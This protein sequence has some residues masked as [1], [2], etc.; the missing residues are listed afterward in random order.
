VGISL[1]LTD[2]TTTISLSGTSPVLGATY[3]VGTSQYRNGEWQPVTEDAEVNLR[4]TAAAIRST[5]AS[6]EML[7]QAAIR[8][9]ETGVGDRVY[10]TFAPLSETAYRSEI[11]DGRVV[12]S[13]DPGLRRL[14]DT[15]PTV[16]I[17]V[18]WTRAPGWDGD[19]T[20]IS[21]SANGQAAS[22]SAR[23][24]T[25]D[26]ANG[27]WVQMAAAQVTG[28]MPTPVMLELTNTSGGSRAYR[29][30]FV[31][32]NA[33]S[34][35]ANLVHY[36]QGEAVVS[37]G[38]ASADG[39]SSGGNLLTITASTTAT[40]Y[41]WT[42]P[43]ADMQRTKG[44]RARILARV[45]SVAD[46][47]YVRPKILDGGGAQVLWSGD[48]MVVPYTSSNDT[49]QDFGIVPLP[50]G[51][52][53]A[54]YAAHRL[55]LEIR[56]SAGGPGIELDVM[57]LTMLDAYRYAELNSISVANNAALVLD[58]VE[59]R[60]YISASSVWTPLATSFGGPLLLQPNTLQRIH[61]LY[62][63]AATAGVPITSTL[64]VRA[65]FR[66]RRLTV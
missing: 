47:I 30:L 37:G 9:Q 7:L 51:G 49:L 29:K 55:G 6:I 52:Y 12:W 23:T 24:L 19:L 5:V 41:Q 27:N 56:V 31:N 18:I 39:G 22:T 28:D 43:A 59:E 10:V 21:L 50:P 33:F 63:I 54:S 48:E 58:G 57:Q 3:F 53:G 20:Q 15:N 45:T 40:T 46:E 66:P 62:E 42:L 11:T 4:G 64:G 60:N 44:R 38:S 14:G 8:R 61:V 2:G 13:T 34:D 25:N 35:P 26:P 65:Y 1:S 17:D 32:V 36:L 16:R